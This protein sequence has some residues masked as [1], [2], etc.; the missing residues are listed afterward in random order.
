MPVACRIEHE[1]A[2]RVFEMCNRG[3]NFNEPLAREVLDEFMEEREVALKVAD[4]MLPMWFFP[5]TKKSFEDV[6]HRVLKNKPNRNHWGQ[7]ILD[8]GVPYTE[9]RHLKLEVT[10]DDIAL[11]LR[12]TYGWKPTQR[13]KTGKPKVDDEVLRG[14][15]WPEAQAFADYLKVDK[16][17]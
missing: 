5:K 3:I 14:L 7:G 2:H 6:P 8:P 11:Y 1:T 16:V 15:P 17:T 13:T 12:R 4:E 10:R 9:V